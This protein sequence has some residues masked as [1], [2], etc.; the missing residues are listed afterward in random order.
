VLAPERRATLEALKAEE[1]RRIL[2]E[3]VF[4]YWQLKRHHQLALYDEQREGILVRALKANRDNVSELLYVVDGAG[5]DPWDGRT[6]H[7][8]I[9]VLFRNRAQVERFAGF[10]PAY[11]AGQ[12]HHTALRYGLT[13]ETQSAPT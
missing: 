11:L 3:L 1:K 5:K 7:D 10:C 8:G 12:P 2:A 4:A 6:A 13:V 9:E